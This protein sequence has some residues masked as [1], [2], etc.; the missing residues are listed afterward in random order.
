MSSTASIPIIRGLKT[1]RDY[2]AI[3]V[4]G[5]LR[6]KTEMANKKRI[7]VLLNFYRGMSV[8]DLCE[9]LGLSNKT[10]YTHRKEGVQNYIILNDG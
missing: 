7:D 1:T 3:T 6:R 10:V 8:K 9:K 5:I 2:Y 4:W